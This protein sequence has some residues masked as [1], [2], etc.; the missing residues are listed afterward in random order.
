M[1]Y[2][3]VCYGR[4]LGTLAMPYPPQLNASGELQNLEV[5]QLA[6]RTSRFQNSTRWLESKEAP[7]IRWLV[8]PQCCALMRSFAPRYCGTKYRIHTGTSHIKSRSITSFFV[9]ITTRLIY[10]LEFHEYYITKLLR[11]C[12]RTTDE[13]SA[14]YANEKKVAFMKIQRRMP[15][16]KYLSNLASAALSLDT[17][18]SETLVPAVM[19]LDTTDK[20]RGV[21]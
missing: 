21:F 6:H 11:V 16:R 14:R 20:K 10:S 5:L 3:E 7:S 2:A 4:M 12:H 17:G 1:I 8:A 18:N 9:S 13:R 19:P 15:R